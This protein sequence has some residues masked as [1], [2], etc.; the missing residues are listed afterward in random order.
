[1]YVAPAYPK[2]LFVGAGEGGL[3]RTSDGGETWKKLSQKGREHFGAF[4]HPDHP[5]WIYMAMTEDAPES[6]LYLSRDDGATWEPFTTLPFPF[7]AANWNAYSFASRITTRSLTGLPRSG[8]RS[9]LPPHVTVLATEF[10]TTLP[11][12]LSLKPASGLPWASWSSTLA[13]PPAEPSKFN[14]SRS[15]V[16]TMGGVTNWPP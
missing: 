3:Y 9:L 13:Q 7:P 10:P 6:G 16:Y 2:S 11:Q 15:P 4:Y 12:S 8:L 14:S 5:K 1:M